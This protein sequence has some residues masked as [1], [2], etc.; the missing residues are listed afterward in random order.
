MFGNTSKNQPVKILSFPSNP[1]RLID[2]GV[3][4]ISFLISI[5]FSFLILLIRALFNIQSFSEM[6]HIPSDILQISAEYLV[7]GF[8]FAVVYFY[9]F[10]RYH[11]TWRSF[12]FN[13]LSLFKTIT[14]V[15]LGFL[16]TFVIWIIIAPLILIFLPFINLEEA[17]GIFQPNM[18]LIAQILLIFYAVI[19]GPLLE[20]VVFRGIILPAVSNRWNFVVGVVL[21]TIIWSL[22][23]FQ[24]NVI[25][26]T[27]IFGIVL[28]YIYLKSQSLWPSYLTHVLKNLI[29]VIAIY[30]FGI[31]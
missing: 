28:S 3:I 16:I 12:G 8:I 25:I 1:L 31:S 29:A 20:E 5:V 27:S 21:S 7:A 18:T 2:A 9:I 23:H 26:F 22:L 17:Q 14:Y 30:I 19:I 10:K 24:L 6:L 15:S 4:L 11:L 13:P